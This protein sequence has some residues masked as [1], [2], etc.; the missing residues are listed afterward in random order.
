M[1]AASVVTRLDHVELGPVRVVAKR[2]PPPPPRLHSWPE[3]L[4][5]I[6]A[7][8]PQKRQYA[9][10]KVDR[11]TAAWTTSSTS[12]NSEIYQ[13]LRTLRARSRQLARDNAYARKFLQMV[14]SNVVGPDGIGLQVRAFDLAPDGKKIMDTYANTAIEREWAAWGKRGVC[15]IRGLLSWPALQR[16]II[17]TIAQDGEILALRLRDAKNRHMYALQILDA[18]RLDETYNAVLNN[19][20]EIIMGVE[21]DG[22]TRRPVAYHIFDGHP[23]D[24]RGNG[25]KRT[26]YAAE[27]VLHDFIQDRPEQVRGVPWMHASMG[28]LNMLGEFEESAVVAARI[29]ASKVGFFENPD[30]DANPSMMADGETGAGQQTMNVQAGEFTELPPGY[31]FSS[32]DPNYPND[33]FDPFTKAVLRGIASGLG[34]SYHTLASDLEGVNYSSI[35]Q[36]VIDERDNWRVIQRWMADGILSTVFADWLNQMLLTPATVLPQAKVEKFN[37]PDW[38]PRSWQWVDPLKDTNARI[39]ARENGM[40]SLRR[41]LAEQGLDIEDIATEIAE[42]NAILAA[43]GVTLGTPQPVTPEPPD[44]A[45]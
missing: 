16:L 25:R 36:G 30:P 45:D 27:N 6:G 31:K 39:L 37:A 32:W 5:H 34:I 19:G 21:V 22:A 13:S 28:R 11:L 7:G 4:R 18:D 15:D 8:K 17:R 12:A 20:N 9:G 23:G 35:R 33:V 40:T 41:I 2:T 42:D 38:Q 29:G 43:A 26:R 10:A 3:V 24:I 44:N 1:A 14:E